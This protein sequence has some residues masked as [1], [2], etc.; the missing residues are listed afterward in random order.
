MNLIERIFDAM[1]TDDVC[2]N[3]QSAILEQT[4]NRASIKEKDRIDMCFINLCG[5]S[6]NTLIKEG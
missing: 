1:E 2:L 4:Y 3:K 5:W 6:L